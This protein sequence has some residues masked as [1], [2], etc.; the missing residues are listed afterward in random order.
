MFYEKPLDCERNSTFW[1]KQRYKDW[2][3]L[4]SLK[5]TDDVITSL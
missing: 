3:P 1:S 2:V 4:N 5:N